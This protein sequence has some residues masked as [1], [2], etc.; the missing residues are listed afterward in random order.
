MTGKNNS[1]KQRFDDVRGRR[2]WI[3]L[4]AVCEFFSFLV[5]RR[6]NEPAKQHKHLQIWKG[7]FLVPAISRVFFFSAYMTVGNC[8]LL[9][10]PAKTKAIEKSPLFLFVYILGVN[11]LLHSHAIRQSVCG[12]RHWIFRK[13]RAGSSCSALRAEFLPYLFLQLGACSQAKWYSYLI[14]SWNTGSYNSVNTSF[15]SCRQISFF[16]LLLE[17]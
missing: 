7:H 13:M 2:H 8:D 4:G 17:N 6:P 11:P 16:F 5:M 9:S 10:K 1:S 15:H 3:Q 12:R 14:N